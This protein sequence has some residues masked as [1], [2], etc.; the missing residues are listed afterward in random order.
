M[1]IFAGLHRTGWWVVFDRD[2]GM[3]LGKYLSPEELL[4]RWGGVE[5][6]D[7]SLV[8]NVISEEVVFTNLKKEE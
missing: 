4:D 5:G 3:L 7:L 6:A 8:E 2:T 1:K